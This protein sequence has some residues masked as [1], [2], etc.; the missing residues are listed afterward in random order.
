MSENET[1]MVI[2]R[3]RKFTT[4]HSKFVVFTAGHLKDNKENMVV[5]YGIHND[6]FI[7]FSVNSEKFLEKISLRMGSFF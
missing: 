2:T 6:Y 4:G 5:S 1:G 7:I 3:K